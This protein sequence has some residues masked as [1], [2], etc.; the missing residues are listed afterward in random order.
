MKSIKPCKWLGF[1]PKLFT[2]LTLTESD[3]PM[4]IENEVEKLHVKHIKSNGHSCH[5][6]ISSFPL[7]LKYFLVTVFVEQYLTNECKNIFKDK[8]VS[9]WLKLLKMF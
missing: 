2:I 8:W 3:K 9:T 5:F 1:K 6:L 7:G 4:K